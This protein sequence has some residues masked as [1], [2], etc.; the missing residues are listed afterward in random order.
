MADGRRVEMSS[1]RRLAALLFLIAFAGAQV[2]ATQRVVGAAIDTAA[3]DRFISQEMRTQRVPGLALAIVHGDEVVHVRGYGHAGGQDITENTRFHIASLSKGFTALAVMQLVEAGLVDLDAPVKQYIP[4]FTTADETS[5]ARITVRQLLNQTSGLADAGFPELRLPQP[6]TPE[7]RVSSLATAEPVAPP[8]SEFHYFNPNYGVLARLVEVV[9][10]QTFSSY[11]DERVF[12]PLGML[13]SVNVNSSVEL[14]GLAVDVTQGHLLVFG[15]PVAADEQDG[16]LGGSGGVISTAADLGNYLVMQL[17]G[18]LFGGETVVS[19]DG[20]EQLQ[21]PPPVSTYAMGWLESETDGERV[22]EH[23]GILSTFYS[24][25]VLLPASGYGFVLLYDVHSVGQEMLAFPHFKEG[26]LAILAGRQPGTSNFGA[27]SLGLV[28]AALTLV[29]AALGV[30]SMWRLRRRHASVLAAPL[31]LQL[32]RIAWSLIPL[33]LLV[34]MPAL[35]LAASG[36]AFGYLT[37]ARSMPSVIIWI[38]TGALFGIVGAL[39]RVVLLARSMRDPADDGR[40]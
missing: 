3:V 13:R 22:L 39:W 27:G 23:N 4:E 5:A 11:L 33:A 1:R 29:A 10:G 20:L 38:G 31:V 17:N 9:S 16:Y 34:A 35:V 2:A 40:L 6:T 24:E 7:E 26:I 32:T 15:A 37:L 8:G 25:A 36:R 19:A 12:A 18:G 30:R 14:P 21:T 28:L